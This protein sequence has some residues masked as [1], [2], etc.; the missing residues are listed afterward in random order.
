M[1]ID[2]NLLLRALCLVFIIEG[3]PPFV[4]PTRFKRMLAQCAEVDAKQLRVTGAIF[5][6]IGLLL[7]TWLST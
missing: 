2:W 5:I 6:S 4:S 7:L 3:V 1:D